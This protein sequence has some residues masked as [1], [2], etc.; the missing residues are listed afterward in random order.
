MLCTGSNCVAKEKISLTMFDFENKGILFY[1]FKLLIQRMMHQLI[2]ASNVAPT[3]SPIKSNDEAVS[4]ASAATYL[5][6]SS[7]EPLLYLE[8]RSHIP[9][10]VVL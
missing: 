8:P 4:A 7:L 1:L 3:K 6:C 2:L 5:A 10:S 9:K